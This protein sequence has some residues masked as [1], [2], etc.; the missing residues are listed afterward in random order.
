M[1]AFALHDVEDHP[2]IARW[3]ASAVIV[4]IIHAVLIALGLAWYAHAPPPGVALPMITIDLAPASPASSNQT[5]E[6]PP[7]PLMQQ[8]DAPPPPEIVQRETVQE[9]VPPPDPPPPDVVQREAVQE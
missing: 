2:G 1:N 5:V 6:L 4:L 7:G 9:Q 8:A 3:S